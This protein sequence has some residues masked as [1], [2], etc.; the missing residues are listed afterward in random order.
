M[1]SVGVRF[2]RSPRAV[3]AVS[4]AVVA[5]ASWLA[6]GVRYDTDLLKLMPSGTE[7]VS[8]QTALERDDEK[9]VWH[10]VVVARDASEARELSDRLRALKV[11]SDVGGAGI[12]FQP[13]EEVEAK[14]A[15]LA[16]L[17]DVSAIIDAEASDGG[18]PPGPL[19]S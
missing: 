19:L 11:V 8:W 6:S 3:L 15:A 1:G 5:A 12:L 4:A 2:H 7:S 14:R 13:R 16:R 9:S 18:G 10:A 17:P